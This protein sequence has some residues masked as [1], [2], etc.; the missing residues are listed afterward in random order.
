MKINVDAFMTVSNGSRSLGYGMKNN[1]ARINIAYR[2]QIDNYPTLISEFLST[3]ETI[4]M[5]FQEITE[6]HH[7]K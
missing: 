6:D 3:R 2:K 5:T 1:Q 4:I 7:W